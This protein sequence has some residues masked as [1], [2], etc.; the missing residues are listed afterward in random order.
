MSEMPELKLRNEESW[1]RRPWCVWLAVTLVIVGALSNTLYLW[2][3]CPLDL[4]GDES[5]YWEWS[6]HLDFGYYSKPPGIAWVIWLTVRIGALLGISGDGS[7]AALMPVVR[8]PAVLFGLLSGLISLFLTRRIFR[9]DRAALTVIVLSAAVPMFAIGSLLITIDSPMYLC[10]GASVYCLWRAVEENAKRETQS[11]KSWRRAFWLYAAGVACA[12]G[13]MFKPVLIAVPI[14]VV[15]AAAADVEL[16]RT[17][18]TWHS[19]GALLVVSLSQVPTILWN[20][21]H[22][23]VTFRHIATQGGLSSAGTGSAKPWILAMPSRVG[24]YIGGQAGGMGGLMFFLLAIAAVLAWRAAKRT[25]DAET[26]NN[27]PAERTRWVFLLSFALPLWLFYLILNFWTN[28]ELNW[29][30]ASY[31]AGMILAA[32]IFVRG[33][34]S[35]DPK[36]RRTWRTWG[37]ATIA[38]GFLLTMCAMNL[39]R[40]YPIAAAHLAPLKGTPQYA[41][42]LFFP[43]KWDPALTKLRTFQEQ[44]A[45][46]QSQIDALHQET[47]MEP[48]II[49]TT[50]SASSSL[51]FYLPGQPFV[52]CIMSNVG[53]RHNQYDLW[54]GLNQKDA[55]GH[56]M[57]AGR[58]AIILIISADEKLAMDVITP[59]FDHAERQPPLPLVYRGITIQNMTIIRGYGFK[60]LPASS[61]GKY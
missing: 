57:L 47:G 61:T 42:S 1:V 10:W 31:F 2:H 59:S 4:S 52:Y 46:V 22:G 8:M 9:D 45:V 32:G 34:N 49:T 23:W 39:T 5:H 14:C 11:V 40:A 51:S 56:L 21:Q 54:P 17:F 24:E 30:A 38:W 25:K 36:S 41:K 20:A 7:G 53:G 19:L 18:K 27:Q 48:L 13:M 33:W 37:I 58:P 3:N 28:T 60:G 15:V 16:Q 55:N 35:I 12:L 43:K 29:P 26:I 6:R 44:A 50:Y